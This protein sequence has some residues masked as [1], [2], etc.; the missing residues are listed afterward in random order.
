MICRQHTGEVECI[1]TLDDAGTGKA[2]R[3]CVS[4]WTMIYDCDVPAKLGCKSC[5]GSCIRTSAADD[6]PNSRRDSFERYLG[7]ADLVHHTTPSRGDRFTY[8][9]RCVKQGG[10][11]APVASRS[12]RGV[13][14]KR[15]CSNSWATGLGTI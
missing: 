9:L 10:A 7:R 3:V 6:E 1:G 4:D 13:V 14:E 5:D 2:G 11:C 15:V 8:V 12:N